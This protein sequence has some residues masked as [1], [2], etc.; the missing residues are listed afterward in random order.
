[1]SSGFMSTHY[2][3]HDYTTRFEIYH[4]NL[5]FGDYKIDENTRSGDI[6]KK[7]V[8]EKI[9]IIHQEDFPFDKRIFKHAK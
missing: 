1:M 5:I 4:F 6:F 8:D 2:Q 7:W 3:C 9:E